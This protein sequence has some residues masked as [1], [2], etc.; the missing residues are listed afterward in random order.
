[1]SVMGPEDEQASPE[2]DVVV[3]QDVVSAFFD[4]IGSGNNGHEIGSG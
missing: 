2:T 1:M 3:H 4:E